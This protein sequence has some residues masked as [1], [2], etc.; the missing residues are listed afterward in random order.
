[1]VTAKAFLGKTFSPE[2]LAKAEKQDPRLQW[3]KDRLRELEAKGK[4]I[5]EDD[6]EDDQDT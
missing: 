3:A 4:V 2:G 6:D 1:L 5:E